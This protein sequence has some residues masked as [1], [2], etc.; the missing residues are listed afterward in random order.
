MKNNF[1]KKI[2]G[3][4]LNGGLKVFLGVILIIIGIAGLFLPF[5][6]GILFI[7]AGLALMG[8]KPVLKKLKKLK[9]YLVDKFFK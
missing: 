3:N 4:S 2:N 7:I 1:F 6:Q 9:D 8:A 5:L